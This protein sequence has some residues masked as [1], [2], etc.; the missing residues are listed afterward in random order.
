MSSNETILELYTPILLKHYINNN[1]KLCKKKE[2]IECCVLIDKCEN[3]VR[4]H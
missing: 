2:I 3:N 4:K 1:L